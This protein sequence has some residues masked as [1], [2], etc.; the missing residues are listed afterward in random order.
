M[1]NRRGARGATR[2]CSCWPRRSCFSATSTG[3]SRCSRRRR[4]WPRSSATPTRSSTPNRS[5]PCSRWIADEWAEAARARGRGARRPSTRI[6]WTTTPTT[7]LAFAA[8]ARLALHRGD[9]EEAQRQLTQSDASTAVVLVR[10]ALARGAGAVA[11]GQGVHG[12]R[13]PVD[14]SP[15]PPR[16][17]R[18]PAPRPAL[19]ALDD[20]VSRLRDLVT[21]DS[22]TERD[23]SVTTQ[24][25]RAAPAPLP[26][27]PPHVP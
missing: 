4:R 11:P 13:R 15:P 8:A 2:R 26:A 10:D 1:P 21:S 3:R 17:R 12:D 24:S 5:S 27:D 25:R 6:G 20:E 9:Q 23:R 22:P 14:R 18:H 16:D 7:V 19:G